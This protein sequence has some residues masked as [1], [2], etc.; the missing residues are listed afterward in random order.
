MLIVELPSDPS[1]PESIAIGQKPRFRRAAEKDGA[2]PIPPRSPQ[3]AG[4]HLKLRPRC[5][6]SSFL[7][8]RARQGWGRDFLGFPLPCLRKTGT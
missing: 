2:V 5:P 7:S 8:C 6:A 3:G 1:T 4:G